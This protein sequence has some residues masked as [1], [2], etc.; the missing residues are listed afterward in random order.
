MLLQFAIFGAVFAGGYY[1]LRAN[2]VPLVRWRYSVVPQPQP[3][4]LLQTLSSLRSVG[5]YLM[6]PLIVVIVITY[7]ARWR[8]IVTA[9]LIAEVLAFAGF[10][11]VKHAWPRYRPH[12]MVEHVAPLE[13]MTWDGSWVNGPSEL[14]KDN[15]RSFGSGHSASAFAMAAVMVWFYPQIAWMIWLAA[16]GCGLSR[17]FDAEHWPTDIWVGTAIGMIAAWISLR[18]TRSIMER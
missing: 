2:D 4:M 11:T 5:Q 6:I 3:D 17:F 10:R 18:V 15:M 7:D 8:K 9:L 12:V 13:N 16:I 14:P 1:L